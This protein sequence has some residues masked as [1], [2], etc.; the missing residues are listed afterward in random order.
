MADDRTQ[1]HTVPGYQPG[2]QVAGRRPI[3]C[4]ADA[5]ARAA[6]G[7][8]DEIA[9]E[10]TIPARGCCTEDVSTVTHS[11]RAARTH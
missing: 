10:T 11:A 5:P 9:P 2:K 8:H 7:P 4:G 3:D 6:S 1:A